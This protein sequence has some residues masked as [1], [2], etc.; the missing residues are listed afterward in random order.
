M[1]RH[2]VCVVLAAGL[3]AGLPA[4]AQEEGEMAGGGVTHRKTTVINFEDDTITG[5]LQTPDGE[6]IK[7][8][9]EVRHESLIRLRENFRS[10]IMQSVRNL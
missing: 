2:I 1:G 4:M 8:R 6:Y 10:L 3:L 5:D 9:K 7:A